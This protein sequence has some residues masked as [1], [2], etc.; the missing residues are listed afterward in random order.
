MQKDYGGCRRGAPFPK[1][2]VDSVNGL[3]PVRQVRRAGAP[4]PAK[5]AKYQSENRAQISS[6]PHG[7]SRSVTV[8]TQ[9]FDA[10]RPR[11]TMSAGF[12]GSMAD[13]AFS[14]RPVTF[15]TFTA[16]TWLRIHQVRHTY[17]QGEPVSA[18][19]QRCPEVLLPGLPMTPSPTA[20]ELRLHCPV[21]VHICRRKK[22]SRRKSPHCNDQ[23]VDN[24]T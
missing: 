9:V 16:N 14:G 10:G 4:C 21:Q 18:S 3:P 19:C 22:R 15:G 13:P 20:A 5:A 7:E 8:N 12:R 24:N 23:K 1:E 17:R 2:D 6:R 11:V